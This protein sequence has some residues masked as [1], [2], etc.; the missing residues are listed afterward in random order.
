[1]DSQRIRTGHK[2]GEAA[3]N[4]WGDFDWARANRMELLETYGEGI[5]L[6]FE[7]QVVGKGKSLP[8]A[9]E[10]AEQHLAP[11]VESITPVI[12]FVSYPYRLHSIKRRQ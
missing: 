10:D 11:E 6:I 8:E 3:P 5:V 2:P 7:Q 9:I 12:F 4:T 1:V